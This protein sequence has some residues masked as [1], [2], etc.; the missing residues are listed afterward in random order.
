MKHK[1]AIPIEV[2]I[3]KWIDKQ[4]KQILAT[5][6]RISQIDTQT[7]KVKSTITLIQNASLYT[8]D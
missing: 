1:I 3:L 5:P 7:F 8:Y 4:V 6:N 2:E